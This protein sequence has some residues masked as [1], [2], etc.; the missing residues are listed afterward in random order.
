MNRFR[1]LREQSGMALITV[2]L[3]AVLGS[4]LV[5]AIFY[6]SKNL[7]SMTGISSRY[8]EELEDAKGI[9]NYLAA[10]IL[11]ATRDLQCGTNGTQI[12]MPNQTIDCNASS[13]ASVY[14]PSNVY[15]STRHQVKVCYLFSVD[16]PSAIEPYTMYGF[17]IRVSN[18]TTNERAEVDFI[19][20]VK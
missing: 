4:A 6:I 16:D 15:D 5:I 7:T 19:Y 1:S 2:L 12:C 8:S 10:T 9:S 3:L 18:L 13:R 20:K 14:I 11:S 17:W